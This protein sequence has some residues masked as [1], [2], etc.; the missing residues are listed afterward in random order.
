MSQTSLYGRDCFASLNEVLKEEKCIFCALLRNTLRSFYTSEVLQKLTDIG[1]DTGLF[2]YQHP[3]DLSVDTFADF[4]G[5]IP[6]T[7]SVKLFRKNLHS[8]GAESRT[9]RLPTSDLTVSPQ[10]IALRMD[11]TNAVVPCREFGREVDTDKIDWSIVQGWINSCLKHT[12][13]DLKSGYDSTCE[14]HLLVVDV[15]DGR[16]VKLPPGVQYVAL[17]YVWGEDQRVKL[18]TQNSVQ[19]FSKGYLRSAIGQLSKTIVDSMDVVRLLGYRYL[20]VDALC[21]VQDDPTSLQQN[22]M[23]MDRVY[24]RSLFTMVAAAG[25]DA[26]HGLPG[27]SSK[28]PRTQKQ[29]RATINGFRIASRLHSDINGT[30]WNT[31]GWTYQERVLPQRLLF[32]SEAQVEYSCEGGCN[33]QEQFHNVDDRASFSLFDSISYLDLTGANLF[34]VYANAVTEYTRRSLGNPTDKLKAFQ[35]ILGRLKEPFQAPFLFG[36]PM[37]LFDVALLWYPIESL[38]RTNYGFPRS[39]AGWNGSVQWDEDKELLNLCESTVSICDIRRG[40]SSICLCTDT[41]PG[42]DEVLSSSWERHYED[43][44]NEI[45]YVSTAGLNKGYRYPRPLHSLS[46]T[47]YSGTADTTFTTLKIQGKIASMRL[48]GQ[49]AARLDKNCERGTHKKC[50]L[51]VIDDKNRVAGTITTDGKLIPQ[52]QGRTHNILALSRSTY[53]RAGFS[54][55]TGVEYIEPTWDREK[56]MFRSWAIHCQEG[57]AGDRDGVDWE[58][59]DDV[60]DKTE[61]SDR[62]PWPRVNVLLLSQETDGCV[63]RIGCGQIHIDAFA[64]N[65]Q[66]STVMLR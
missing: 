57:Q 7:L 19:F 53:I 25:V 35:G 16:I 29:H 45:Y 28:T 23:E 30:W 33:F 5:N 27:V 62:K 37:S 11:T 17:S 41:Y 44:T 60:F 20:W 63:E 10:L 21:I 43:E 14:F 8:L 48:T 9:L 59:N 64:P 24:S 6:L 66:A 49:H 36:L 46:R 34:A 26:N 58:K 50:K 12:T 55:E 54:E 4:E 61:F 31:R 32:F 38:T 3:L 52:L 1:D 22:V 18:R 51:A 13:D 2:L 56:K 42:T 15:I 39:W 65:A 47:I 40:E